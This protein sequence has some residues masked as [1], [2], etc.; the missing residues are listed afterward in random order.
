MKQVEC[1]TLGRGRDCGQQRWPLNPSFFQ[2]ASSQTMENTD[3]PKGQVR[4]M[5]MG[6][7]RPA[8]CVVLDQE[9]EDQHLFLVLG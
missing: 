7:P 3:I 9:S 4:P 5:A 6:L 2:E 8:C 1:E